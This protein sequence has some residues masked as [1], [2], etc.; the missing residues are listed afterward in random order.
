MPDG[1]IA[2]S[3]HR[4][5]AEA[6]GFADRFQ[7]WRQ[8]T[9]ETARGW[10]L[11]LAEGMPGTAPGLHA[12]LAREIEAYARQLLW[13][14]LRSRGLSPAQLS[15]VAP[16]EARRLGSTPS[17]P[18][19][20]PETADATD[21]SPTGGAESAGGPLSRPDP[22]RPYT[23]P[24]VTREVFE[25]FCRWTGMD[26]GCLGG[27]EENQAGL[28]FYVVIFAMLTC[29]GGAPDLPSLKLFKKLRQCREQLTRQAE[30]FLGGARSGF[31]RTTPRPSPAR[32]GVN[33]RTLDTARENPLA[34]R[35]T[36]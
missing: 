8:I 15:G 11:L 18:P 2:E 9:Q 24:M 35:K 22:S 13:S 4:P 17:S 7:A 23:R 30:D 6:R 21:C 31:T 36:R 14:R 12:A 3:E 33:D 34:D 20:A 10:A 19:P 1:A 25:R 27:P 5:G 29:P 32:R 26:P 16:I 28:V